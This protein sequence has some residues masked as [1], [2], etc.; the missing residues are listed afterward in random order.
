VPELAEVEFYRCQWDPGL[1]QEILSV[2]MGR[3]GR[4]FR[5]SDRKALLTGLVGAVLV[6]STRHGKQM[7]FRTD[8]GGWL[9]IHL[10]MTGELRVASPGF[11][12]GRHDHLVFVQRRRALVFTDPRQ[13]GRIRFHAD[14]SAPVWWSD[15][16]VEP[17]S[18]SFTRARMAAFLQRHARAPL[19]AVLLSQ[20]GFPGV[21]NWMADETLWRARLLPHLPAG[22]VK[23]DAMSRL[24]R[25]VRF[26]CA[27]ALRVVARGFSDPPASWLFRH[28]WEPGGHCPRD[29]APLARATIGGRTT[30]WCPKCQKK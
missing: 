2:Q 18:P 30:A 6:S 17:H 7:L 3:A 15:L 13:F 9:G 24:Y 23:P 22:E 14:A 10:G 21:G 16:P 25:A 1:Q 8:R 27:G 4:V 19:K 29:G 26:V 12:P 11:K 28:R 20:Q 5:G